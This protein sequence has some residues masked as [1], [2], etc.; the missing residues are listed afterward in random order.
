VDKAHTIEVLGRCPS[1]HLLVR[2]MLLK[3]IYICEMSI[4]INY[5][6]LC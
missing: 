2:E 1:P 6:K 3:F 4:E 5:E